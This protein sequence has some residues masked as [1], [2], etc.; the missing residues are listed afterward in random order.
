MAGNPDPDLGLGRS[1]DP[2]LAL[3]GT[4]I[5]FQDFPDPGFDRIP[6]PDPD[7]DRDPE[8]DPDLKGLN[9]THD[10]DRSPDPDPCLD[11]NPDPGLDK[12]LDPDHAR[13]FIGA[14]YRKI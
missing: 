5:R 14:E 4:R 2:G 13:C 9:P 8:P 6:D 7:L 1:P 3:I 12:T 11:R 10:F